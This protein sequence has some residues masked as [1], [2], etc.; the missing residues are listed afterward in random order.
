MIISQCN[1][2]T[3]ASSPSIWVG[4]SEAYQTSSSLIPNNS[5]SFVTNPYVYTTL[6]LN[7][8]LRFGSDNNCNICMQYCYYTK[9]CT[10]TGQT[11]MDTCLSRRD[12]KTT[13]VVLYMED[14]NDSNITYSITDVCLCIH[15]CM[16]TCT[17]DTYA[18]SNHICTY[19]DKN[20]PVKIANRERS[21]SV[22]YTAANVG[23]LG[24]IYSSFVFSYCKDCLLCYNVCYKGVCVA[25]V[26]TT[27]DSDWI[28]CYQINSYICGCC[29]ACS[30]CYCENIC[31]HWHKLPATT[32]SY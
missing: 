9:V 27:M 3:L 15:R 31:E 1:N 20:V 24:K 11:C 18:V 14:L 30:A 4:T 19:R 21:V 23:N 10:A 22:D 7:P 5:L 12:G 16:F 29:C 26:S 25:S 2:T 28:F 13:D 8:V 6:T 32:V 17:L